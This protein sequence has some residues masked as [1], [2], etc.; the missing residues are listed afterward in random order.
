[1][2]SGGEE[3]K[4]GNQEAAHIADGGER[5]AKWYKINGTGGGARYVRT[6][7]ACMHQGKY[8]KKEVGKSKLSLAEG[9]T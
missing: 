1:M 4:R 8:N 3:V 6:D 9:G 2:G 5:R 7:K